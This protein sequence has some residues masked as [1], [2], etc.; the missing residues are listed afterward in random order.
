MTLDWSVVYGH[1]FWFWLNQRSAA[2]YQN[3]YLILG[4]H[5]VNIKMYRNIFISEYIHS[6]TQ[7]DK[8]ILDAHFAVAVITLLEFMKTCRANRITKIQT[9]SGLAKALSYRGGTPNSIA[10]IIELD[11]SWL[12]Q[13]KNM[14]KGAIKDGKQYFSRSNHIVFQ[15]PGYQPIDF[16]KT[17]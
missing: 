12:E 17:L 10:H 16:E 2:Q 1:L 6:E 8:T 14:I 7:D 15:S 9:P 5:L 3:P 11:R 13:I 4:L